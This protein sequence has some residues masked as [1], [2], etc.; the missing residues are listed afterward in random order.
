MT[1]PTPTAAPPALLNIT[2]GVM[3]ALM[4]G[5]FFHIASGVLVPMVLGLMISYVVMAVARPKEAR[6]PE[7]PSIIDAKETEKDDGLDPLDGL[8]AKITAW[9]AEHKRAKGARAGEPAT[10]ERHLVLG[11]VPPGR[12]HAA[13]SVSLPGQQLA[14]PRHRGGGRPRQ[15]GRH[16]RQA[17]L[18]RRGS[19]H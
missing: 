4:L 6:A 10:E 3:L 13:R 18:Y 8:H 17:D 7:P 9:I 14:L 15:G 2:L 12:S 16:S 19:G 11:Q 1:Q 5:W